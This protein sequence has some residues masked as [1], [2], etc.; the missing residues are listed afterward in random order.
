MAMIAIG[1]SVGAGLFI[2]SGA[3]IHVAGPAAL[4]SYAL[5]GLLV[6]LVLR[7]LGEMVVARPASGAFADYARMALGPRAGFTI[8][9]LYWWMYC[10]LVAAEA[11]AGAGILEEWLPAP[12]WL[13]SLLLLVVMTGANLVSVR[14]FGETES[15]FSLI[16]VATIVAFLV[17]GTLF[18]LGMWPGSSGATVANLWQHG[19]FAP[20]GW[21]AVFA[22]I[23]TVLFS[24]GGVEIVTIAAGES[25]EP[26]RNVARATTNVLWRIA[27]FYLASILVVVAVLPWDTAELLKSPFVSVMERVGVPAAAPIMEAVVFVAVLSVL[28]AA[29][30]TTSRMLHVLTRHG[31]A[32]RALAAVNRRGVPTRAILLGT[33]VGYVS[34]IGNYLWP[35]V[36]FAFLLASVG[37]ILLVLFLVITVSQLVMGHRLRREE[38]ERLTLPMWGF[39][40]VTLAALAGLVAILVAMAVIPDQR[41]PLLATLASCTVVLCAYELRRR[42]GALPPS[43]EPLEPDQR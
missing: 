10:V 35:D 39:P 22:A 41:L 42:F 29:M 6:L 9:W 43:A 31:D 23:V 18:A 2:G 17:L 14:V 28:N 11:V 37:A 16:K 33:V 26:R 38:P 12:G 4:V 34:V 32:P 15:L 5:A 40:Y 27:L 20:N 21:V 25:A 19:G 30:Y 3:V 8:G 36:V 7:A 13:L 24:F 1:G